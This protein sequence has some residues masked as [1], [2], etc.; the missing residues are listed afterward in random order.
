M[1]KASFVQIKDEKG[2]IQVYVKEM[3]F[4]HKKINNV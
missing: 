3:K 4:A 1:G 2:R